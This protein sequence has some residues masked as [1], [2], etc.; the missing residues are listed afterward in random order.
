MLPKLLFSGKSEIIGVLNHLCQVIAARFIMLAFLVSKP[1][2]YLN[3]CRRLLLLDAELIEICYR[4]V[5]LFLTGCEKP[6]L[7]R[8]FVSLLV[9]NS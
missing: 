6:H 2:R 3:V 7:I 4:F 8:Q 1:V 5:N 9:K